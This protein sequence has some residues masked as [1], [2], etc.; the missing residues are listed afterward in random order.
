VLSGLFGV[1]TRDSWLLFGTCCVRN[2][3]YGYISVFLGIY[4]EKLGLELPA[5]GGVFTAAL[6]GGAV[7]TLLLTAVADRFGR[8]AIL[9]AGAA[10]MAL[11]GMVFAVTDQV[12][13]LAGAAVVGTISPSGKD[14]GPFL[15]IE[16][17][18]LPQTT[19]AT[20]RTELFSVYNTVSSLATAAGALVAGIPAALGLPEV[21]GFRLLLWAYAGTA[22]VLIPVFLLLSPAVEAE[23]PRVRRRLGHGLERSRGVVLKLGALFA[24]DSFAGGFVVQGILALWFHLRFGADVGALGAI[25][26]GTNLLAG[27]S[28]L[29]APALARRFGLLN[30]M[31]FAHLPSNVLLLLL[32]FMPTLELAAGVLLVR[33]LIA[34]L[35]VPTRQSYTMAIIGPGERA[36]AGGVLAVMRNAASAVAPAFA[37]A[38]LASPIVA[39]PFVIAGGLKIAYDLSIYA[40]F[41]NVYPPEETAHRAPAIATTRTR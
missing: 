19:P 33:F 7:M 21:A 27:I 38:T 26:F 36:A 4:L 22:L 8:R 34:Q 39:L 3:A 28:F 5:I 40:V 30:T 20:H 35:D 6:V 17:A 9:V 10:L 16:Q 24:L 37:G 14:I 13:L 32:P 29:A 15:S 11:A 25:F 18:M 12:L 31:V 2:L 1:L 41:R 23:A